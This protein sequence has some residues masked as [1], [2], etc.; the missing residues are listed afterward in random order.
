MT[1]GSYLDMN[2]FLLRKG[3]VLVHEDSFSHACVVGRFRAKVRM[4]DGDLVAE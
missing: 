1:K 3:L 2:P 4:R